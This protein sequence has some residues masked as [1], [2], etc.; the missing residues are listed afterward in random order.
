MEDRSVVKTQLVILFSLLTF[1]QTC[2][3][4][5]KYSPTELSLIFTAS[6][7]GE[8][9]PCG[10]KTGPSGGLARKAAYINKLRSEGKQAIILDSGD[11]FFQKEYLSDSTRNEMAAKASLIV[12]AFNEMSTT[13]INIGDDD[14]ILGL[15]YLLSLR[16]RAKFH[17][18]SSNIYSAEYNKPIFE[19]Y[20]IWS[21]N[22]F[23]VGII[24]LAWNSGNY[25]ESVIVQDP[26]IS[27]K[28]VIAKIRNKVDLII[29][30]T[31][32]PL[33]V[34]AA[35][36]DS[37]ADVDLFIGGHDGKGMIKPKL[38]NERGIYKAGNEG[39]SLGIIE[40][41]L[42]N[43]R[44]N[45][46]EITAKLL[47]LRRVEVNLSRLEESLRGKTREKI[48]EDNKQDAAKL[49]ELKAKKL[50]I[51]EEIR[52]YPNTASFSLL[53]LTYEYPSDEIIESF[54]N[55]Y[56]SHFPITAQEDEVVEE[57]LFE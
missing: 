37:I 53:K 44:K 9:E 55:D 10:C 24:G 1:S 34:E 57:L 30:L 18:I 49:E 51:S 19:E 32:M 28:K 39:E 40:L 50:K 16:D 22:G 56:R 8:V 25:P 20:V 42:T 26:T 38:V 41:K 33:K 21:N 43:R 5:S 12:D 2:E 31:H 45:I 11:L 47:N 29:A 4:K 7:N 3:E 52:G 17:F 15:D 46:N 35:L 6:V 36:A 14:F 27:A 23:K 48:Y 54:V 13:A